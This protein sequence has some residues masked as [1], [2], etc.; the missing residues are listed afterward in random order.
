MAASDMLRG[1]P[2]GAGA[3]RLREPVCSIGEEGVL[4]TCFWLGGESTSNMLRTGAGGGVST[5]SMLLTG[6]MSNMDRTGD[7]GVK[8]DGDRPPMLLGALLG[9][10]AW[11]PSSSASTSLRSSSSI[12]SIDIGWCLAI[13]SDSCWW[14]F[15]LV[16]CLFEVWSVRYVYNEWVAAVSNQGVTAF[17]EIRLKRMQSCVYS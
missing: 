17:F 8:G 16:Y 13:V 15:V 14:F 11:G 6:A 3:R 10:D 12:A 1:C 7:R 9:R 5:S 4:R 2:D